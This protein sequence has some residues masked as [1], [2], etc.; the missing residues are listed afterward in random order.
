VYLASL[1]LGGFRRARIGNLVNDKNFLHFSPKIIPS[2]A[3]RHLPKEFILEFNTKAPRDAAAVMNTA[4]A[5]ATNNTT[6][7]ENIHEE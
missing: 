1:P 2:P 6:L 5:A 4:A 7:H 3:F